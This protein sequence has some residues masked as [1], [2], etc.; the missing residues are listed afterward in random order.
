MK[1]FNLKSFLILGL[2]A[3]AFPC[4]ADEP[5][6][7]PAYNMKA[8]DD[9]IIEIYQNLK[10]SPKLSTV[11]RIDVIS[12]YFLDQPY[13]LGP[14]GEGANAPFDQS[15]LYRTDAFDCMTF[16][17]MILALSVSHDFTE[18]QKNIRKVNYYNGDV[19][20]EK[21]FHI[22][23]TDW[24]PSNQRNGFIKDTTKEIKDVNGK[25][26]AIVS[27][28][29]INKPS[30]IQHLGM[31]SLKLLQPISEVEAEQK[32]NDLHA[33]ANKMKP[34]LSVVAYLPLTALYN[35]KG[36]ANLYLFNQIPSGSIIEIVRPKW[37]LR[38]QIGTYIQVSHLGF[39]IQTPQGLMFRNASSLQHKVADVL[40]V[41]Y[42][43]QYLNSATIK[44]INIQ[45]IVYQY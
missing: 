23:S 17:N 1:K 16:A 21:R 34:A 31:S 7:I 27:K 20:F 18:F 3:L 8:Y 30:W 41:D 9:K 45:S 2:I 4:F 36:E 6:I 11:E 35:E 29:I 5:T 13:V 28:V 10:A 44:G 26:I 43:R 37:D 25:P 19:R 40:L 39:A 38:E 42:L 14:N 15:P 32:L 22:T 33:L 24:N 12:R